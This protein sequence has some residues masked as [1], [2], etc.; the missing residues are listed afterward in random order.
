MIQISIPPLRERKEDISVLL[1]YFV[2]LASESHRI[3]IPRLLDE[4]VARLESYEWPGNV[5]EL[6]NVVERLVIRAREGV[7]PPE[8]LPRKSRSAPECR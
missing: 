2:G 8:D 5:R 4:T 3:P 6:K 1:N 7:I